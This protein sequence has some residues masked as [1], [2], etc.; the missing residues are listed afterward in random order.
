M[1]K[2]NTSKTSKEVVL[3]ET[4]ILGMQAMQV[5]PI[6]SLICKLMKSYFPNAFNLA[7]FI[8]SCIGGNQIVGQNFSTDL[9]NFL[10]RNKI[11]LLHT[12]GV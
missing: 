12:M 9:V 10:E 5:L 3:I 1:D 6:Y 7:I 11:T 8:V 4:I 2:V